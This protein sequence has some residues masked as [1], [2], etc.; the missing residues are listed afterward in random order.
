MLGMVMKRKPIIFISGTVLGVAV[1]LTMGASANRLAT[2]ND[3][4]R[5]KGQKYSVNPN[6]IKAIISVESAGNINAV[7]PV[8]ARGVM[9]LMPATAER[10][11]VS[12][13]E[14]FSPERNMEAGVKYISY[15]SRLFNN[16]P[17]L[18]AAGYN[19]GEGAVMKYRGIPPYKE[20]QNYAPAVVA[21][22]QLL[23]ACGDACYTKQHMANPQKYL[24]MIHNGSYIPSSNA[25]MSPQLNSS[26]PLPSYQ[27]PPMRTSMRDDSLSTTVSTKNVDVSVQLAVHEA[28]PEPS[29]VTSGVASPTE[30]AKLIS[31][32]HAA[33]SS[34]VVYSKSNT[35]VEP[36][37]KLISAESVDF[38][39]TGAKTK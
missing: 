11:G 4:A 1:A 2:F 34:P 36:A 8:G 38:V 28:E 18:V 22:F 27:P 9:Q 6:F 19:A 14:L 23:E 30:R 31:T 13:Q 3:L 21:R 32:P 39:Q 20:T 29:F 7:S 12:R 35:K 26:S 37:A 33:S 15:L 16:D 5:E 17:R 10:M 24:S 25:P